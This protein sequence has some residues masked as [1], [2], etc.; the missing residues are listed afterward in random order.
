MWKEN[1][2]K[3]VNRIRFKELRKSESQIVWK[4]WSVKEEKAKISTCTKKKI[5]ERF[6]S[7]TTTTP[8]PLTYSMLKLKNEL[9]ELKLMKDE[10][11]LKK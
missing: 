9:R 8:K 2:L 4:K 11:E 6:A 7:S 10:I 3:I 5:S 1:P